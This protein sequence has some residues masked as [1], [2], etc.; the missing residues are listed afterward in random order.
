MPAHTLQLRPSAP[1]RAPAPALAATRPF[2]PAPA[3]APAGRGHQLAAIRVSAPPP[4]GAPIQRMRPHAVHDVGRHFHVGG[5]E[6]PRVGRY[7]GPAT[8]EGR[9][10]FAMGSRG[11]EEEVHEDDI[12]G[13]RPTVGQ[14]HPE[15]RERSMEDRLSD[16]SLVMLSGGDLSEAMARQRQDPSLAESMAT[17]TYEQTPDY[18]SYAENAENMS[19]LGVPVLNNLDVSRDDSVS[20]LA[21]VPPGARL[22]FQMPRVPQGTPGYSTHRLVTD[23]A[24]IPE[25]LDRDDLGVSITTP[26]PSFYGSMRTHNR[27]YGLESGNAL[28]STQM[29]VDRTEPDA[30]LEAYGYSHRQTTVDASTDAAR[31]RRV[32]HLAPRRTD[33]TDEDDPEAES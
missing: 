14:L 4:A 10:R 3:P 28:A 18:A 23:T 12:Q 27:I 30:N 19:R 21:Q 26:V 11:R 6:D 24:R 8:T 5:R 9:H 22:H 33:D 7:L 1:V 17:T 29:R 13:Y 16:R 31:D 2:A 25:R 15:G 32:Y 20:R